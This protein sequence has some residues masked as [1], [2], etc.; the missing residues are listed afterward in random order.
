ALYMRN[1][2]LPPTEAERSHRLLASSSHSTRMETAMT[3]TTAR[4]HTGKNVA[5][6]Q[7]VEKKMPKAPVAAAAAK[8]PESFGRAQSGSLA[9]TIPSVAH[10]R[11]GKNRRGVV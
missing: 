7:M 2:R 1:S 3:D 9:A 10:V 4:R 5:I 8:T 11:A 6:S